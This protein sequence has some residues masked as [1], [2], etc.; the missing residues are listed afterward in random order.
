MDKNLIE[1]TSEIAAVLQQFQNTEVE[2]VQKW[3]IQPKTKR[4]YNRKTPTTTT[5][6]ASCATGNSRKLS[7]I[8]NTASLYRMRNKGNSY[9]NSKRNIALKLTQRLMDHPPKDGI[10]LGWFRDMLTTD[11]KKAGHKVGKGTTI[12]LSYWLRT[13]KMIQIYQNTT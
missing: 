6:K 1:I 9:S 4:K 13:N 10:T 5:V 8:A 7:V 3:F 11:L 12:D 2:V